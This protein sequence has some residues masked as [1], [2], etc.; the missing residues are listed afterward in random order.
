MRLRNQIKPGPLL[1]LFVVL[2]INFPPYTLAK[3]LITLRLTIVLQNI[4]LHCKK[5]I[6]WCATIK[7]CT[8]F[9]AYRWAELFT[10]F[11]SYGSEYPIALSHQKSVFLLMK[12]SNFIT[13][14]VDQFI[15]FK[16]YYAS[17]KSN[18]S[19]CISY[20]YVV[21]NSNFPLY[22]FIKLLILLISIIVL[23]NIQLHCK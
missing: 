3:L 5:P 20:V 7:T 21:L 23:Q 2:D 15:N 10:H 4:Q 11:R 22:I 17:S 6:R 9:P 8:N 13:I 18:K 14:F 16:V 1:Y 12:C 19:G